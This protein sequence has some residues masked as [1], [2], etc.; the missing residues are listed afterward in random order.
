[1]IKS[2]TGYGRGSFDKNGRSFIVEIKSVNHRYLDLNIKMPKNLF[3]LEDRVRK[4]ISNKVSRGKIDLFVTQSSY[5]RADMTAV[6]NEALGDSYVKCLNEIKNRYNIS[7]G[8]SLGLVSKFPEVITLNQA[9]EDMDEI[10]DALKPAL[11]ESLDMLITMR[12]NEGEKLQDNIINKCD[13]IKS[14]V[15]KIEEKSPVIISE[16]KEKLN[17]KIRELLGDRQIDESRI[18]MEVAIFA[19]KACVDEEIVRL[20]SH[21]EQLKSTIG[22]NES[23]GRKLDFIVQEMNRET[24]TIAS[25]STDIEIINTVLNIKNEIEKIREQVQN[26]E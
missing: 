12:T 20:N 25:K 19:D 2:M 3:S 8:V 4:T 11:D 6:F 7:D 18:A 17:E 23:V 9:E 15:D 26:I 13:F 21:L 24:N 5:G 16:Y 14:Y 1:M 22:L 10:W